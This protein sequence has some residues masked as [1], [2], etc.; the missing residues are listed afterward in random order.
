LV[1]ELDEKAIFYQTDIS[2]ETALDVGIKKV[3]DFYGTFHS[4][5]NCAGITQTGKIVG[6]KGVMPIESFQH[7][8]DVN[9]IGTFN[10]IRATAFTLMSNTP[11][12]NGERGVYINTSS[13]AAL[14]GQVGQIAYSSSKGGIISMT[15]TLARGFASKGIRVMTILPGI[16]DT[17]M[18]KKI[19]EKI[20][21]I[22]I[23]KVPF[24]HRPGKPSEFAI[25]ACHIIQNPYLNAESIRLD[26][27]LWM[28]YSLR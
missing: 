25:L 1:N 4:V 11:N 26:G 10:V 28:G 14:D 23:E 5:I 20:R 18:S 22:V 19:P 15:L 8:I 16:M 27:G 9:L 7:A 21:G 12:N 2:D 24:P 17:P 13:I 3:K 6:K